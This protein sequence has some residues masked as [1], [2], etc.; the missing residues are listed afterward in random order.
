[1]HMSCS[2]VAPSCFVHKKVGQAR[3]ARRVERLEKDF[4][5]VTRL[6]FIVTRKCKEQS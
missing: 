5:N 3:V 4:Q 1:M 2:S 6:V